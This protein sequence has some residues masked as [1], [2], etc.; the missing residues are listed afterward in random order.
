MN[1]KKLGNEVLP[2][3]SEFVGE[4]SGSLSSTEKPHI[5]EETYRFSDQHALVR[6][7]H[8]SDAYGI[9]RK[10]GISSMS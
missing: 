10:L 9:H 7:L 3:T 2:V 4:N 6:R 1:N 5:G 8:W